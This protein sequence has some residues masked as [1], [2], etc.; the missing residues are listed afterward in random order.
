VVTTADYLK[1][2]TQVNGRESAKDRALDGNTYP[3]KK[4]EHLLFA[5]VFLLLRNATTYTWK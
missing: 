5:N 1:T 2:F 4:L 3:S